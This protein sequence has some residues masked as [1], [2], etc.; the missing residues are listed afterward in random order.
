MKHLGA[1]ALG[2]TLLAASIGHALAA[3]VSGGASLQVE[4]APVLDKSVGDYLGSVRFTMRNPS[5]QVVRILK[6]QTPFFGV[7]GKLFAI[8]VGGEEVAYTGRMIKR[9]EPTSRDYMTLRPGE[10]RS[11]E[12]D[13]SAFYNFAKSGQYEVRYDEFLFDNSGRAKRINT[14]PTLMW[15]DGSDQFLA[16]RAGDDPYA[17]LGVKALGITPTFTKCTTT[18][19][20]QLMTA[21]NSADSYAGNAKSYF[22]S[23]SYTNISARYSTWFGAATSSR[24]TTGKNHFDAIQAA[25]ATKPITVDCGCKKT[26]FAYVYP[27][28][29]YKIYVCKAFWSAAN[30]GTDSRAGT[31]IHEMSHFNAVAGTDDHVY[32]QS[33]AKSLAL[34]NPDNA[35][36]NADNHEYFSENTPSQN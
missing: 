17:G 28:Q 10:A 7:N 14:T 33:G 23:H 27:T 29:P 13:L 2:T 20:S 30:T 9:G 25:F 26:Y 16:Q 35:L 1:F 15:V 8:N 3:N 21:L 36:D 12:L 32:G 18:Q 5:D 11:V 31:L 19:K 6:W 34:S 4:M 24:Y 22:A